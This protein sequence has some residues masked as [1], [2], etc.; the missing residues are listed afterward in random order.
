MEPATNL[1]TILIRTYPH[2]LAAPRAMLE[3]LGIPTFTANE[4]TAHVQPFYSQAIGG[5]ELQVYEEDAMRARTIL[6]EAGYTF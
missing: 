2:E 1:T 3:T 4:F 5:V 6:E